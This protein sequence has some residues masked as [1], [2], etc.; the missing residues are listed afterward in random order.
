MSKSSGYTYSQG[1]DPSVLRAHGHRTAGK[2]AAFLLPH[3]ALSSRILDVG[4]GPGTIS[5]GLAAAAPE[6]QVVAIDYSAD[7]I[8]VAKQ[9]ALQSGIGNCEFRTGNACE[10]EF[11]DGMF[12]VVYAH[13]C[14]IHLEDPVK[15]LREMG[16]VCKAGGSIAVREGMKPFYYCLLFIVA[17]F[18]SFAF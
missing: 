12:D 4:C 3:L 17:L 7:V 13:Q 9:N 2:C 8:E 18:Q 15:A 14:L 11:G 16:R 10:L 6:G 1:H 5:L